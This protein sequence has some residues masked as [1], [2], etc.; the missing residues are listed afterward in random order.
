MSLF[1]LIKYPVASHTT[2]F[3]HI[4]NDIWNAYMKEY[5]ILS[6]EEREKEKYSNDLIRKLMLEWE[7]IPVRK[8]A[9]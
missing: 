7:D 1:T 5:A 2:A 4:P 3:D 9:L 6:K 8:R